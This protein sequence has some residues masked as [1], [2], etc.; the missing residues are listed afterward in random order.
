MV[1]GEVKVAV[2]SSFTVAFFKKSGLF[3]IKFIVPCSEL[4]KKCGCLILPKISINNQS[5]LFYLILL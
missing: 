3:R 4:E 5:F 1:E 2:A